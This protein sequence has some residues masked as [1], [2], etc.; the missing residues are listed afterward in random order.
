M[1]EEKNGPRSESLGPPNAS[2]RSQSERTTGTAGLGS[3]C[4][5]CPWLGDDTGEFACEPVPADGWN[6]E[7]VFPIRGYEMS[8]ACPRCGHRVGRIDRKRGQD[9]VTCQGCGRFV[10]NAPRAETGLPA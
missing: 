5:N 2:S 9:V 4:R 7:I 3:L 10:Y 6:S 1:T 8:R